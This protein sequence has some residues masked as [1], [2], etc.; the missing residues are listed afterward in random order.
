MTRRGRGYSMPSMVGVSVLGDSSDATVSRASSTVGHVLRTLGFGEERRQP[1]PAAAR[2]DPACHTYLDTRASRCPWSPGYDPGS[3]RKAGWGSAPKTPWQRGARGGSVTSLTHTTY[4]FEI[5][6]AEQTE[7]VFGLFPGHIWGECN[8]DKYTAAVS[9]DDDDDDDKSWRCSASRSP[10]DSGRQLSSA[11]DRDAASSPYYF[12]G[13]WIELVGQA[14]TP[15][16]LP[17]YKC[18]LRIPYK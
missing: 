14:L 7:M 3:S 5:G 15:S 9:D 4:D 13:G 10:L 2:G 17:L 8:H 11:R 12:I 6:M 18:H 1:Y 16:V